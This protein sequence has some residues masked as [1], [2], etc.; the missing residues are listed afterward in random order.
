MEI[1]SQNKDL[2][3]CSQVNYFDAPRTTHVILYNLITSSTTQ[4]RNTNDNIGPSQ[5]LRP[6]DSRGERRPLRLDFCQFWQNRTEPIKN[7]NRA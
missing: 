6:G 5:H 3:H 2:L 1:A 4:T 7:E